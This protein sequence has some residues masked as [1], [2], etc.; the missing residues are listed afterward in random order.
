MRQ[1]KTPQ[2]NDLQ[3][4][5]GTANY[6]AWLVSNRY[7]KQPM[8]QDFTWPELASLLMTPEQ[9][10]SKDGKAIIFQNLDGK[11]RSK[12]NALSAW[13]VCLDVEPYT[14]TETGEI[15]QPR[16]F[17]EVCADLKYNFGCLA[18]AYTT[19]SHCVPS[20]LI[21]GKPQGERYR[22]V[23]PLDRALSLEA[24]EKACLHI[25]EQLQLPVVTVDSASWS[26]GRMMYLPRHRQGHPFDAKAFEGKPWPAAELEAL[27]E[28]SKPAKPLAMPLPTYTS[29]RCSGVHPYVAKAL[30]GACAELATLPIGGR[31]NALNNSALR[32]YRFAIG[33]YITQAEVSHRLKSAA[34]QS[35]LK[36]PAVT[37]TLASAWDGANKEGATHPPE[38]PRQQLG[39]EIAP[40]IAAEMAA[41]AAELDEAER[42]ELNDFGSCPDPFRGVMAEI[43]RLALARQPRQQPALTVAAALA[44]MSAAMH[45]KYAT[46]TGLRGNLYVVG[47]AGSTSGKGAPLALVQAIATL[48]GNRPVSNIGSG[49]GIEDALAAD[50]ASRMALAIDEVGHLLGCMSGQRA[51]SHMQVASKMHLELY[52]A[53]SGMHV[54][55]TLA[56]GNKPSQAIYNPY[57]TLYGT[58]THEKMQGID[59]AM[60]TDGTLGRCLV[61]NGLDHAPMRE[62]PEGV[63]NIW[64]A[65]RQAIGDKAEAVG[66]YG[67][68]QT[69]PNEHVISY[70][71]DADARALQSAT[72]AQFNALERQSDGIKR[73]LIGR[74]LEQAL[75]VA[76]VLAVW[77]NAGAGGAIRCEHLQ[78]GLDFVTYSQECL[79]SFVEAM[80]DS[81]AIKNGCKLLAMIGDACE[82]RLKFSGPKSPVVNRMATQF[83]RVQHSALLKRSKLDS[84]AFGEAITW[85]V[86]TDQIIIETTEEA[87]FY[88]LHS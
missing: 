4:G 46:E 65:L 84:R 77:D 28:P 39:R 48:A 68:P 43:V 87:K 76:L 58:T 37:A 27:P 20:E 1:E 61:V 57:L 23:L 7:E 56:G 81:P 45:G 21:E 55:R 6:T 42:E 15:V 10:D 50:E 78:W 49:Q 64:G 44:G 11:G 14:D 79:L 88:L 8:S 73:V 74:R 41:I 62:L 63:S 52:S 59:P 25:A 2:I 9:S 83:K 85:L 66:K 53:S 18:V 70:V 19:H 67:A 32:M 47:L 69:R 82:G 72:I 38:R 13:A 34:L 30:D 40:D 5:S 22:L 31:N 17:A 33:E 16:P 26:S 12:A 60:I 36:E 3:G 71:L 54:T 51:D 29:H 35:G 24:L 75:K 86:D 80:T